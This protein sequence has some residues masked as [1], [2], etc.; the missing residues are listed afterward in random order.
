MHMRRRLRMCMCMSM[1][2]HVHGMHVYK[3]MYVCMHRLDPSAQ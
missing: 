3:S 1:E 2:V